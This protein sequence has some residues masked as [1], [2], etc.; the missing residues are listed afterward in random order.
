MLVVVSPAKALNF[1]DPDPGIAWT[2]PLMMAQTRELMKTTRT[3]SAVDLAGLMGLSE[4]LAD[5]NRDRYRAFRLEHTPENAKQAVLA[6]AGDTYRGLEAA[7]LSSED[8]DHAQTHLR[9]ISGLYGVLR[10]LDLIQPYRLEMG[11]RLTTPRGHSLYDFWGDRIARALN[12]DLKQLDSRVV[13]NAASKE[14]FS[15]IP[16]DRL[17]A[18]VIT[19]GV[20][21]DAERRGA[22][23]GIHRQ[24]V[25]RHDGALCHPQPDRQR[26][27]TQVLRRRRLPL[28]SRF[29]VAVDLCLH[30]AT[31]VALTRSCARHSPGV[32]IIFVATARRPGQ[33]S[34][35]Q[36]A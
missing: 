17:K 36:H 27:G 16:P 22:H 11:T 7:S 33:F 5:L 26:R 15:A 31:P 14:Y 3:L 6:F 8:L 25:A 1:E 30:Q 28:R 23:P 34:A 2:K 18:S 35:Q 19:A 29:V 21:G 10:P 20:Q 4:K 12:R 32:T 24:G 9:I 13:L